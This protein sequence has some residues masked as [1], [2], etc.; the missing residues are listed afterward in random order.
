VLLIMDEVVMGMGRTGKWFGYQQFGI[1]PD[2]V[3]MAKGVAS[4]YAAIACV[5]TTEEVPK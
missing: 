4:G 5:A 3:C 1:R 2:I